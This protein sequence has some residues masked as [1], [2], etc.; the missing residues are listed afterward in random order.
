MVKDG[1]QLASQSLNGVEKSW[2]DQI[3]KL[4]NAVETDAST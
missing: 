2:P 3:T 4:D 1:L